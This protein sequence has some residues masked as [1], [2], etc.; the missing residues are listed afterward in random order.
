M[1]SALNGIIGGVTSIFTGREAQ[2]MGHD[3]ANAYASGV[4]G[5]K[6]AGK[7]LQ[8][9][10]DPFT[11]AA[12]PTYQRLYDLILGGDYSQFQGSPGYQFAQD[13]AQ[14][15][16]ERSASARGD[17]VSGRTLKELDER[18]QQIANQEFGNYLSQLGGLFGTSFGIGEQKAN[19]PLMTQQLITPMQV[20]EQGY[21]GQGNI[22]R[23]ASIGQGLGQINA[24]FQQSGRDLLNVMTGGMGG[25]SPAP[26]SPTFQGGF[27]GYGGIPFG[28][29]SG[30]TGV[31]NPY[32]MY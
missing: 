14:K 5:I 19:V 16:I 3:I 21:R 1:S 29:F 9:F 27:G 24:G 4:R 15:A 12:E 8:D 6:S 17:I 26:S 13:E 23:T 18:S 28:G 25:F 31:S 2:E 30:A 11:T 20:N 22:A 32:A 10:Y 7:G